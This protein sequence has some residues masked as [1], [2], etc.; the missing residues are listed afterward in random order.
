MM[1]TWKTLS[2]QTILNHSK[3]LVV[4]NHAVELPDGRVIE[5]WPWVIT[6]EFATILAE[7]TDGR[8]LVFRQSKYAVDGV[9]LAPPGG[10]IEPGEEPLA[11]AQRELL[12]ETGYTADEWLSLG[13]YAVDSNRGAG[14]AHLFLA[15]GASRV[16]D[17][18]AD[19][20]EDQELLYLTRAEVESALAAGEFKALPWAALVALGLLRLDR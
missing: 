1:R 3:F 10:Y 14:V 11:A 19:D 6:P 16:T 17:S 18:D 2:K 13:D 9:T 5:D 4:E 20:L 15:R 8:F 7:T 12:E